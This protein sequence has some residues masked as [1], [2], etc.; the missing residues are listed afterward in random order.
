MHI[1][2]YIYILYKYLSCE[3]CRPWPRGPPRNGFGPSRMGLEEVAKR[4]RFA[5]LADKGLDSHR[6]VFA[7]HIFGRFQWQPGS[8]CEARHLGF[9]AASHSQEEKNKMVKVQRQRLSEVC[10][11]YQIASGCLPRTRRN[12][13]EALSHPCF[14]LGGRSFSGL[15]GGAEQINHTGIMSMRAVTSSIGFPWPR[16]LQSIIF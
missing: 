1:H 9:F 13:P 3:R 2:A 16:Q 10:H 6:L 12:L 8:Q 11:F 15:V 5:L 7:T 14:G 4:S